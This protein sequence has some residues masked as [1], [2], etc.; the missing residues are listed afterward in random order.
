VGHFDAIGFNDP[1][2][3]TLSKMKESYY[4]YRYTI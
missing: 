3:I 1:I 2:T 4:V